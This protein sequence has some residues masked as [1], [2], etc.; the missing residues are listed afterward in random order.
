LNPQNTD[1]VTPVTQSPNRIISP[2]G[3]Q[4]ITDYDLINIIEGDIDALGEQ[5]SRATERTE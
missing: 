2:F 4:F 3:N 5:Y 1:D